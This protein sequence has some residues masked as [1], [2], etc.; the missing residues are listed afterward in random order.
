MRSR[1][2]SITKPKV[3]NGKL[4][5]CYAKSEE[6]KPGSFV[7]WEDLFISGEYQASF[8]YEG[9]STQRL[10][11]LNDNMVVH[12]T[13]ANRTLFYNILQIEADNIV[14]IGHGILPGKGSYWSTFRLCE[15]KP[16]RV[17]LAYIANSD[18][19]LTIIQVI[20]FSTLSPRL[21]ADKE[22]RVDANASSPSTMFDFRL[23]T[24]DST[25][26]VY[27]Y[28]NTSRHILAKVITL[29]DNSLSD[30]TEYVLST[31]TWSGYN[32]FPVKVDENTIFMAHSDNATGSDTNN[33][34]YGMII[35]AKN[36]ELT[37]IINKEI[38]NTANATIYSA[39]NE[40]LEMLD[41]KRIIMRYST[42]AKL[43]ALAVKLNKD[44]TD[45]DIGTKLVVST[46]SLSYQ[47]NSVAALYGK[48]AAILFYNVSTP[49]G[50]LNYSYLKVAD[51]TVTIESTG[52]VVNTAVS[53]AHANVNLGND[54]IVN[55][56]RN[57]DRKWVQK[58]MS[59]VPRVIYANEKIRGLTRSRLSKSQQGQVWSLNQ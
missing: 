53:T 32:M 52:Q 42:N 2:N 10:Y 46:E 43:I 24:L 18:K 6:I 14:N 27:F 33:N 9:I 22:F 11:R 35:S 3:L 50:G 13:A 49:S 23:C 16:G 44:N 41:S 28:N 59:T 40:M 4:I 26:F 1:I 47:Y 56:V 15:L 21:I 39:N 8:E 31:N 38:D 19:T 34:L 29:A 25:R 20:D 54:F 30:G 37:N 48:N 57:G 7:D 36:D 58:I 55:Y 51:L 17:A 5:E 12:I 45:F